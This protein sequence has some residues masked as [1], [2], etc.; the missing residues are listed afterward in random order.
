VLG[1]LGEAAAEDRDTE[2]AERDPTA[3][4]GTSAKDAASASASA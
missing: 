1:R 2:R 3:M 4:P